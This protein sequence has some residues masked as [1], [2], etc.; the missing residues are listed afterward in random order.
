MPG[1]AEVTAENTCDV[2]GPVIFLSY[3]VLSDRERAG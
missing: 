2:L 3:F 1:S